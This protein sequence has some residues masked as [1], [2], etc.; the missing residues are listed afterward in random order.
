[1]STKTRLCKSLE[2]D[3]LKKIKLD[4]IIDLFD[5]I[6][7]EESI[8]EILRNYRFKKS[9]VLDLTKLIFAD[10][11]DDISLEVPQIYQ[12]E[13]GQTY[14]DFIDSNLSNYMAEYL[15][16]KFDLED[17]QRIKK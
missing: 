16:Q 13:F 2:E 12:N 9:Q 8:K 5:K 17:H 7:L 15:I 10:S 6:E 3:I 4:P 1:M 14:E 11:V